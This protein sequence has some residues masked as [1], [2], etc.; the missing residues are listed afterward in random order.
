[1]NIVGWSKIVP[2]LAVFFAVLKRRPNSLT[3]FN[4]F[5]SGKPGT[6]KSEGVLKLAELLGLSAHLID[7]AT[8]DDVSEIA[9]MIDLKAN[10]ERGEATLIEGDA[11]RRDLL[12]LDEFLNTR[13]HVVP[14]FRLFLQG[15]LTLFAR[16]VPMDVRSIVAAG[17]LSD[18]MEQGEANVL[19]SPTADRFV[20]IVQTP[21][22]VEMTAD[23]VSAVLED[24]GSDEFAR[25][26]A[27]AVAAV[28]S[29]F[30]GAEKLYGAS[31]TGFVRSLVV[32]LNGTPFAFEG[33]RGK[34]LRM[35]ALAALALADAEPE[36][37]RKETVW[38]VV[39]DCLSYHRLSGMKLDIP[40]LQAAFEIAYLSL[41]NATIE[42]E[43]VAEQSLARKVA[44]LVRYLGQVSPL[45]KADVLGK[46]VVSG[47]LALQ[48]ACMEL[49]HSPLFAAEP[50]ELKAFVDRTE[51]PQTSVQLSPDRLVALS[52]MTP[53][54][55]LLYQLSG[56]EEQ[57][58]ERLTGKVR[59]HLSDW[60]VEAG[61]P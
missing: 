56:G 11:L 39:R 44:L 47:D 17:N 55:A 57:A 28:D 41:E 61:S 58:M 9:G 30:E 31:V 37:D 42:S 34:L 40:A 20:M 14:Q 2:Q 50:A 19:D 60:G 48:L 7:S 53:A 59:G 8:L 35:F 29:G 12:V 24:R 26:F 36:R 27:R 25:I 18:D 45:T 33:R 6:N 16:D 15:R 1:M 49:V 22:L 43:I 54:E 38:S 51:L 46:V 5:F 52:E 21:S 32:Q 4:L 23:E 3:P 13:A 10:R